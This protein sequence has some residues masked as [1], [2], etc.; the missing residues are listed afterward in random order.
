MIY[1]ILIPVLFKVYERVT[2]SRILNFLDKLNILNRKGRQFGF[3]KVFLHNLSCSILETI[4]CSFD[5]RINVA[6][7]MCELSKASWC[8]DHRVLLHDCSGIRGNAN[9]AT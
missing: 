1:R 2:L 7:L 3:H 9:V 5:R 4:T 8:V 6:S